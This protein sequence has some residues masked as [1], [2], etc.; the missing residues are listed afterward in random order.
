[1]VK[2]LPA[3]QGD[4]GLIPGLG[5]FPWNGKWLL[6]P[7]FLNGESHKQRSLVGYCPWDH[8]EADMTEQLSFLYLFFFGCAALCSVWDLSSQPGITPAAP[9]LAV[10]S[11]NH[12]TTRESP[13]YA[14]SN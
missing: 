6:I 10:W 7:V 9:A 5:R 1:M 12:R 3:L 2:N 8:K 13:E 4:P 11:P 14:T